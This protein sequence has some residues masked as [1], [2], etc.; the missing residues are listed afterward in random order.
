MYIKT[1]NEFPEIFKF[2]SYDF[3]NE[4]SDETKNLI[5]EAEKDINKKFI[6]G[7]SIIEGRDMLKWLLKKNYQ[8]LFFVILK[9]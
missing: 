6:I 2:F 8:K 3:F 1:L 5:I 9:C 4:I 7:K